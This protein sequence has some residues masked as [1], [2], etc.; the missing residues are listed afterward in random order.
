MTIRHIMQ[1]SETGNR[2]GEVC[3][4]V[5]EFGLDL[6]R[7]VEDLAETMLSAELDGA[8][9]VGLAAPQIDVMQRVFVIREDTVQEYSVYVNPRITYHAA[10][11]TGDGQVRQMYEGCMSLK[12][13]AHGLVARPKWIEAIWQGVTGKRNVGRFTGLRARVFAHEMDH[14]NGTLYVA[15]ATQFE[16]GAA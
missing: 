8:K 12:D 15:R 6:Q 3:V 4:P 1:L 9:A 14:L 5:T 13:H 16:G 11:R 7:L 10:K 2:L